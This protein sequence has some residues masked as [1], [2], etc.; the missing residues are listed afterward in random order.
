MT[1]ANPHQT[2]PRAAAISAAFAT[3]VFDAQRTFRTVMNALAEPGTEHVVDAGGPRCPGFSTAM[4]AIALTVADFETRLWVDPAESREAAD[5]LRFHTGAPIVVDRI[6][7]AF[8]FVTRPRE[9]GRLATFAQGTLEYPDTSATL[10]VDVESIDTARGWILSGPGIAGTRRLAVSPLPE[11]LHADLVANR[12]AFPC[13]VDLIFCAGTRI[14]ALPRS[15][16]V[17]GR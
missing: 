3:P 13:G 1:A 17:G 8:A 6:D 7:A 10:V 4:T 14:V 15:T 9:L 5:Y 11:T 16:R 2:L 12:A